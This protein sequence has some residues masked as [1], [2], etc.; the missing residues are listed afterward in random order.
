MKHQING[1][2]L[3]VFD[4]SIV[5]SQSSIALVSL[6]YFGGSSRSWH[7]VIECLADEYRCIAPDLRGF[8]DSQA[9]PGGYA[10]NDGAD[11]VAA[12]IE[13]LGIERYVLVGHSMGGKIAL[14]LAA[15]QPAGLQ[16]LILLAP[17]PPTPEPMAE[18]ERQRLLNGYGDRRAAEE[19]IRKITARPLPDAL[20]EQAVEDNLKSGR[21]AWQAWLQ[22]GSRE[23]IAA[24]M[25]RIKVATLVVAGEKDK[26]MTPAVLRR[27][28][29]ERISG[30][31]LTVVP[32]ASH[33]LP[34]EAPAK[35]AKLIR[36]YLLPAA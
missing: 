4:S 3:N 29:V 16:S 7:G 35:V 34:I 5:N 36:A 6:H 22:S 10:V 28:V 15:R 23:D 13:H 33:L 27:E 19:T 12:L 31:S 1:V 30:A 20:F 17:S 18:A 11:D 32:D 24:D 26:G 8:G 25:E 14:A 2:T 21:A 9:T